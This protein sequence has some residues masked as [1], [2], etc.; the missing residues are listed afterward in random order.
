MNLVTDK[1]DDLEEALRK[2]GAAAP[3]RA[4]IADGAQGASA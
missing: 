4:G 2:A 3:V 1:I